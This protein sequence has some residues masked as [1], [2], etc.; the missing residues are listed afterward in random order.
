MVSIT[1]YKALRGLNLNANP[2]ASTPGKDV[3]GAV[4]TAT[5]IADNCILTRERMIGNRRGFA[6]HG[7]STPTAVDAFAEYQSMLIE[8]EA[9]GTLYYVDPTAGTRTAYTGSY[10]M[11][12]GSRMDSAVGRGSLFFTSTNGIQKIDAVAHNPIRA[13]MTKALDLR[14]LTT[15]TGGGFAGGFTKMGYHI[16][17]TR[18]DSNNQTVRSDVSTR[19]LVT[20]N[21]QVSV[22]TLT[23]TANVATATTIAAH[24][25]TTGDVILIAGAT[26]AAYN[27]SFTITVT[28]AT[29]FTYAV[30]GSPVSPAVG[31]I[32]ASKSLNVIMTFTVPWDVGSADSFEVW[33]T[34]TVAATNA[35]P[36][37]DCF[38]VSKTL[39]VVAAG[40]TVSFTDTVSDATLLTSTPLYTNATQAGALQG[41]ARPPVATCIATYKDYTIYGNASLDY[42]LTENMLA[43]INFVNGTSNIVINDLTGTRTYTC[44]ATEIVA[45][46]TFQVF[47]GG[48]SVASNIQQTVQS[49]C[50]VINGDSSGRWYAEYTS[51]INDNPG[52]FR[53]WA[54]NPITGT[55]W[56][57][58]NNSTTSAQFSPAIPTSGNTVIAANDA[59][60]NRLFYSKQFEPD[61]VPILNWIDAGQ[62]SQPILRVLAS[63]DALYIIKSDGV[64]YL[65][66]LAAPFS[67]IELDQTCHC[68]SA[69]TAVQL[70]NAV[71]MLS[72]QGVVKLSL[73]GVTV[74]SFDIEPAIMSQALSLSNL[75][76]VAFAVAHEADRHYCLF[77]PSANGDIVAKHAYVYHTFITEW[78]HWT[79]PAAAGLVMNLNYTM[80]LSSG[81][82][83][84]VLKQRKSGDQTDFGDE[85]VP[86]TIVSQ[87]GLVIT[88]TWTAGLFPPTAG[89]VLK[90]ALLLSKV[91]SVAL[92]SGAT[93][94]LTIDRNLTYSAGAATAEIPI[95]AAVR[96]S[97]NS[98]GEIGLLK[99]FYEISFF[100]SGDTATQ[101]MLEVATNEAPALTQFPITRA[102]IGGWGSAGWGNTGW[103]DQLSPVKTT[104]WTMCLPLPDITGEAVSAGWIHNV[105][106]E[107]FILA[108][109]AVVF[110]AFA[111]YETTA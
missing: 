1:S 67:M 33:R 89:L 76:T 81:L 52:I 10:A 14:A 39:N 95:Y 32:L 77:L 49:L 85:D 23:Q 43:T 92:V 75:N 24:G 103:G 101:A 102:L 64:F 35:D 28:G 73:S 6:Y 15:G 90:Q 62:L 46:Q 9:S 105:A 47:T 69:A 8:H 63:R 57:T 42:Q 87:T 110:D 84:A 19:A 80:Y 70:N 26:L 106:Q 3:A 82:E 2:L 50:H 55:F 29:T 31:T 45:T 94:K 21:T 100:L 86:V 108:Q 18:I 65:S 58:C 54:R 38:L 107:Q 93:Y 30:S 51:G 74:I 59:R 96:L 25:Y 78:T 37:D 13:G 97:P 104:P 22:V 16:T 17:W 4:R 44:N 71:Y 56:L 7:T 5:V 34:S 91:T 66:G 53:I 20:N 41:N 111:D 27:G 12:S 48:I 98:C 99:T 88:V 109:I 11:P 68:L 79:K 36:G 40:G 60:P 83:N 61:H 72:N